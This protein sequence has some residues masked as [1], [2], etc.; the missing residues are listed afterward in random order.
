MG[1]IS[2]KNSLKTRKNISFQSS[3]PNSIPKIKHKINKIKTLK[4]N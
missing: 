1:N 3:T 4:K 2:T